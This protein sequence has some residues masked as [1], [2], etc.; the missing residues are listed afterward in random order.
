MK[1]AA[2]VLYVGLQMPQNTFLALAIYMSTIPLYQHYVTTGRTWGPTPLEDQQMAGGDHVARGRPRVPG[3]VILLVWPGC[4]TR[5]AAP[6]ARIAAG[7]RG[8]GDP[9]AGPRLAAGRGRDGAAGDGSGIARRPPRPPTR[10]PRALAGRHRDRRPTAPLDSACRP[11]DRR[12]AGL[13]RPHPCTSRGT[14]ADRLWA[15][16]GAALTAE[17]RPLSLRRD[18]RL[19]VAP[20][21][22]PGPRCRPRRRRRSGRRGRPGRPRPPGTASPPPS[23]RRTAPRRGGLL[24][25]EADGRRRSPPRTPS[26]RHRAAPTGGRS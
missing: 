13:W 9:G 6:W 19:E 21:S 1:P 8:G 24:G 5:S 16:D 18:R 12:G 10:L 2:K 15:R 14:R 25:G 4:A 22:G 20:G 23:A 17:R 11:G 26:R 7:G 3:V